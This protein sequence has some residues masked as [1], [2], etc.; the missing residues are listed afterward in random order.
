[1]AISI[2][3]APT[4]LEDL[5]SATTPPPPRRRTVG[6]ARR[7]RMRM[8]ADEMTDLTKTT[9]PRRQRRTTMDDKTR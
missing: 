2:R 1:M 4:R 7:T 8:D 9:W 6:H 5:C 3:L